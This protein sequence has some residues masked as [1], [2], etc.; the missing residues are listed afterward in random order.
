VT[1]K[2]FYKTEHITSKEQWPLAFLL[3]LTLNFS[4]ML[5]DIIAGSL[6]ELNYNKMF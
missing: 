2:I 6:R 3:S 4:R 5:A 1:D